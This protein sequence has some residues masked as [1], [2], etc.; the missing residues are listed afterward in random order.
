[1]FGLRQSKVFAKFKLNMHW[2]SVP[3]NIVSCDHSLEI[4]T[5]VMLNLYTKIIKSFQHFY[6]IFRPA[7]IQQEDNRLEIQELLEA[8]FDM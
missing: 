7:V 4:Q 2:Q 8:D 1:M 6:R 5:F 3:F